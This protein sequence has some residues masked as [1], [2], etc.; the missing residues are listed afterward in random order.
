MANPAPVVTGSGVATPAKRATGTSTT[1]GTSTGSATR[2]SV[3]SP[4]PRRAW[5]AVRM[6]PNHATNVP[7]IHQI[8]REDQQRAPPTHA[9]NVPSIH[10]IGRYHQL[11][12]PPTASHVQ[13]YALSGRSTTMSNAMKT[14]VPH[15]P[16]A[17]PPAIPSTLRATAHWA[18]RKLTAVP[19]PS[20]M[21]VSRARSGT[22]AATFR[23]TARKATTAT[24]VTKPSFVPP[25]MTVRKS[26]RS[27]S[28]GRAVANIV[29]PRLRLEGLAKSKRSVSAGK[30][31]EDGHIGHGPRRERAVHAPLLLCGRP[32]RVPRAPRQE[33]AE[34]G[35]ER[36]DE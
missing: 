14:T 20:T 2:T 30:H 9:T 21:R 6:P 3:A 31:R 18:G 15:K 35:G 24:A 25:N 7:S 26:E 34:P 12:P 5:L 19:A 4:P 8:G 33:H 1:G 11:L 29:S 28:A 27:D 13:G 32:G 22:R 36:H 16:I 10:Q 17:A 23:D